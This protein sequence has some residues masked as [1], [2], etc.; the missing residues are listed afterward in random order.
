MALQINKNRINTQKI[1]LGAVLTALV[2]ILQLL[3]TFVRFGPFQVS[4]VLIPIVIGAAVCGTDIS[5]W[6]GLVFGAVVL[7]NGDATPFMQI[8]VAG[9][10]STVLLK[11]ILCGLAA[12][13]VYKLF[14]KKNK[15]LAVILAAIACPVVNTGIFILG[16]YIFFLD[17]LK[18]WMGDTFTDVTAYIFLGLVGGNFLFE[19][20]TNIILSPLVVKLIEY[21][22]KRTKRKKAVRKA[23]GAA[24]EKT[25]EIT[26]KDTGDENV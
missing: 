12:G 8:S 7:I 16:C 18:V 15:L 19:L 2:I 23:T 22:E 13:L 24:E 3:G 1:V 11:G 20:L 17:T 26:E 10:V 9:T 5:T 21:W 14:E 6:L 4:L 25:P